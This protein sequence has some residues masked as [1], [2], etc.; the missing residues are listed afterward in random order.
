MNTFVS[1]EGTD[2]R[3]IFL[4]RKIFFFFL[5]IGCFAKGSL[6]SVSFK[7]HACNT[8][9][10]VTEIIFHSWTWLINIEEG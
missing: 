2:T 4:G 8:V 5:L 1:E 7:W 6:L 3:N 9:S 10:R